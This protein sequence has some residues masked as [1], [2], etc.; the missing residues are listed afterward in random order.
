[1]GGRCRFLLK[2]SAASAKPIPRRNHGARTKINLVRLAP[3]NFAVSLSSVK[4]PP[5]QPPHAMKFTTLPRLVVPVLAG[6][7]L[8]QA[9]PAQSSEVQF[10]AASP[11][12]TVK[13]R[14]GL[15]DIEIAYS[16]PG[17]KGRRIF[18]GLVGYDAVWRTGANTATSISFS[19]PVKFGGKDVA[20]GK[21]SLFTVPG[22]N[23][24]TVIL[25]ENP[26]QWGAYRYEKEKDVLRVKAKPVKLA[27][28]VETFTID[29]N[30]IRDESATLSLAWEQTRVSVPIE[31]DVASKLVPQIEAA[32][33]AP[34]GKKPYF[35]AAQFYHD[36]DIDLKKA[37]E[38]ID[39]AVAEREAFF[40]KFVQAKI[41]AKLGDK[42]GAIAAAERTRELALKA[43]DASYVKQSEDL[44]ASQ[45]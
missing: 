21:Y 43:N 5:M 11:A 41:L 7:L 42:A 13:Q 24:W 15:T 18:G 31:I 32:M 35:Q 36:H 3:G 1:M 40:I 19:T 33:A 44:I 2:H 10:P 9:L 20:A 45:R 12:S 14:V 6:I 4:N 22:A 8:A 17:V 23:E 26:E 38:W 28:P 37:R 25:N 27:T 30:D 39:A 34:G 16:R 29:I